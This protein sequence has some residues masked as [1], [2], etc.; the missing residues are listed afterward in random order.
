MIGVVT[1]VLSLAA[2][3]LL[4]RAPVAELTPARDG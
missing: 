3:V 1:I 4:I 2:I